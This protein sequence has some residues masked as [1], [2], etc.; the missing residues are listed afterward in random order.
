MEGIRRLIWC[1]GVSIEVF[2]VKIF[3]VILSQ[4]GFPVHDALPDG[5]VPAASVIAGENG[6]VGLSTEILPAPVRLG[7]GLG[8]DGAVRGSG[9]ILGYRGCDLLRNSFFRLGYGPCLLLQRP[10]DQNS[11]LA[12]SD[13][14]R[15]CG[16]LADQ[17]Q[18]DGV[19]TGGAIAPHAAL[20]VLIPAGT[21]DNRTGCRW[22]HW[23]V[24]TIDLIPITSHQQ[25][26][27]AVAY[28]GHGPLGDVGEIAG[29]GIVVRIRF[30]AAME[31]GEQNGQL[32]PVKAVIQ[33]HVSID[34]THHDALLLKIGRRSMDLCRSP[35]RQRGRDRIQA[36]YAGQKT[37]KDQTKISLHERV[38]PLSVILY[39]TKR[40][41][42]FSTIDIFRLPG[43]CC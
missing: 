8:E 4:N 3:F 25:H 29:P 31:T 38:P 40:Q 13:L 19:G 16:R 26:C 30:R 37:G 42:R 17:A 27:G 14:R 5:V 18:T 21:Q 9:D 2:R 35:S 12:A 6:G 41:S 32:H 1:E 20:A 15:L 10:V 23:V 33:A 11:H 22:G 34:I 7:N 36:E 39:S 43:S 24:G 28:I